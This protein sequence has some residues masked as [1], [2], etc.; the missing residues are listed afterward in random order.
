MIINVYQY[1]Y[2]YIY[3]YTYVFCPGKGFFIQGSNFLGPLNF[4]SC[5]FLPPPPLQCCTI[6]P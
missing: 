2:I 1:I 6:R 5:P 4:S 3:I